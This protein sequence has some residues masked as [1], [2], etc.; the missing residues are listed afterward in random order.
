MNDITLKEA[1][2]LFMGKRKIRLLCHIRPDGDA[3]G[4]AFGLKYAL[5]ASGKHEA[6]VCCEDEVPK[7]LTFLTEGRTALVPEPSDGEPEFICSVDCS[8]AHRIGDGFCGRVDLKIDHHKDGGNFAERNY[9]DENA[10]A[11][12]EIIFALIKELAEIGEGVLTPLAATS[13]YA[14][15]SSDTGS[16]KYSNVT[17]STMRAAASLI[18]AG[19]SHAF[20]SY[21][22]Y[23][24]RTLDEMA[25]EK[26]MLEG[27]ELYLDGRVAFLLITEEMKG[28]IPDDVFGDA[29]SRLREIEGVELSVT[30][31]QDSVNKEKYKISMRSGESVSASE[32]CKIFG[33]G[34]HERAAGASVYAENAEKARKTVLDAVL[35]ALG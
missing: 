29:A 26:I 31:R 16:F 6:A 24:V 7:R 21:R 19:A 9:T 2:R 14:A 8:E 27:F 28:D 18:D 4:S 20:A 3:L 5:E 30:V 23:G 32:L 13:L 34:G 15:I 22:L 12:G 17:S 10:A 25:A 33:G 35:S 11:A 1:A